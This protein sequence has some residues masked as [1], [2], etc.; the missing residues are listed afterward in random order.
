MLGLIALT[1]ILGVWAIPTFG[2]RAFVE[3]RARIVPITIETGRER[4]VV[5]PDGTTA[6]SSGLRID[7]AVINH[8]PLPVL[9]DFRGSAFQAKLLDRSLDG[10]SPIWLGSGDDG[11]LEQLDES[12][13]GDSSA[14]V[15]TL[16]PGTTSLTTT[17]AGMT[18]VFASDQVVA[19]GIYALQVSAYGVAGSAQVLSIAEGGG[20]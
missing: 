9:I 4:A 5:L 19:P 7:I 8:Y 15:I 10:G 17:D 13:D 6:R 12:P 14:R 20:A 2:G 11:Q 18:L 1:T 3:V 16:A